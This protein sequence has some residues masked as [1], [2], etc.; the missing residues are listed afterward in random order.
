GYERPRLVNMYGITET[1]V[2]VTY[3]PLTAA[4]AIAAVGSP[5]GR[6]LCDLQAY[7]LDARLQPVPVGV[8]GELFIG[9]G[10]LARGYLGRADVTA[11]RFLPDPFGTGPGGRLYRSGDKVRWRPDGS[12]EFLGRI[13][14]QV[15]IHG[16]R[17]EPGEIEAALTAHPAVRQAVVMAR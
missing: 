12:L 2:H 16:Y 5:I 10:G 11:E 9:G 4:D 8:P 15:K 6:P 3:H 14:G 1:T 13:D 17:I 7:V